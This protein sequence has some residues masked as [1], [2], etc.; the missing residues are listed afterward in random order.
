MFSIWKAVASR[1]RD[2]MTMS[3]S[4][5]RIRCTQSMVVVALPA[6]STVKTWPHLFLTKRASFARRPASAAATGDDSRPAVETLLKSTVQGTTHSRTRHG[7]S[8]YAGPEAAS[9]VKP[10]ECEVG[11][12]CLIDDAL[13]VLDESGVRIG[14]LLQ[15]L[16]AARPVAEAAASRPTWRC[17]APAVGAGV[18]QQPRPSQRCPRSM[19]LCLSTLRRARFSCLPGV[20]SGAGWRAGVADRAGEHGDHVVQGADE[21]GRV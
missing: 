8:V 19:L 13:A 12:A 5:L 2:E 17:S 10:W 9:A 6:G 11:T 21:G 15:A 14:P 7:M 1:G 4:C 20:V 18:F 3:R 16:R